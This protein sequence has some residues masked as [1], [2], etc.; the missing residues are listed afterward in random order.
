MRKAMV[1]ISSGLLSIRRQCEL[2][3]VNR[4]RLEPARTKCSMDDERILQLLDTLHLEQPSYGA[5]TLRTILKRDFGI[6]V[7]RKRIRRLMQLACIEA[8]YPKPRT[9][10][11]GKGH[12][13][14]PYL[15]RNMKIS[16]ADEVWCSDITYIP[17]ARGF[18]YLCAVMDWHTRAVLGWAVSTSMDTGLCLEAFERAIA[19]TGRK[20]KIMN[21]DQGS[22]YSSD[23]WITE[24]TDH[25]IEISMD[26]KGRWV[27]NVFIERL[28]RSLKYEEIY[29]KAYSTPRELE[30]GVA[31]WMDKYNHYRPHSA[32]DGLT[33]WSVYSTRSGPEKKAA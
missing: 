26:G 21:T 23:D 16:E 27:D 19:H 6:Q 29:L 14:Y 12:K 7:G 28:W 2:L 24:M 33:P 25:E 3:K 18:C 5:R 20:P 15:L 11:P 9:S 17:M 13:K 32:H 31:D 8:C 4:N 1:E 10:L 30:Q 22:Q